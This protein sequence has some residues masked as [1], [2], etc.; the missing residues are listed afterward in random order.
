MDRH[1][2]KRRAAIAAAEFVR[3]GMTVGLGTGSTAELLVEEL[4]RRVRAGLTIRGVPTSQ[5]TAELAR[6]LRIPLVELDVASTLDVTI[7][8]ADEITADGSAIKG[9]GGALC[10]EKVVAA[11][12]A[13]TRI[14]VVDPAKLVEQL[15]AFPL[16]V[17]VV[18]FARAPLVRWIGELG[19]RAAARLTEGKPVVT[20]N[21]N[22]ILD[23]RFGPRSDWPEIA[24][25]LDALPGLVC[26]GLFWQCFD[27]IVIGREDGAEVIRVARPERSAFPSA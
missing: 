14:A 15:G 25:R 12:T 3:D 24:R 13:G 19:G 27:V 26:H 21:G 2:A 7:D 10:R 22:H 8:G 16:P 11:A 20:D 17:E 6:E 18:P 23:C 9:G 1:E 4:G 5:R